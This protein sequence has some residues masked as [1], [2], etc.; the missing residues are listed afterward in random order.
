MVTIL[1]HGSIRVSTPH[2]P[3]GPD[4]Y[5]ITM[6]EKTAKRIDDEQLD[7]IRHALGN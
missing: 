4:G 1:K 7:K 5:F 2:H 3:N 6:I